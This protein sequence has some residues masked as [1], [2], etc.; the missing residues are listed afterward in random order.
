MHNTVACILAYWHIG[1]HM[2]APHIT[3]PLTIRPN[4]G[5]MEGDRM[6]ASRI[7]EHHTS[8]PG[9]T[10]QENLTCDVD[11]IT[12]HTGSLYRKEKKNVFLGI[13][14]AGKTFTGREGKQEGEKKKLE[15]GPTRETPRV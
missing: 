4:N 10:P 8:R 2:D 1:T 6:I 15:F 13:T 9:Q 7:P 12:F 11:G 14:G 3:R 5:E